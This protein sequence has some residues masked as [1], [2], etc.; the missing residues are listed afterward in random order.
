MSKLYLNGRLCNGSGK[1]KDEYTLAELKQ[2]AKD[3]GIR[4]TTK[5]DLCEKIITHKLPIVVVDKKMPIV[6]SPVIV[7]DKKESND[8]K[9]SKDKKKSN[10]KKKS[11]TL[12]VAASVNLR[13][14]AFYDIDEDKPYPMEYLEDYDPKL[15][16]EWYT[17]ILTKNDYY[18]SFIKDIK[19][20]AS[21]VH[22]IFIITYSLTGVG[23]IF[24]SEIA[25]PDNNKPLTVNGKDYT[26]FG[27]VYT[28]PIVAKANAIAKP[29]AKANAKPKANNAKPEHIQ[30]IVTSY[31][32]FIGANLKMPYLVSILT[33]GSIN[34]QLLTIKLSDGMIIDILEKSKINVTIDG[35]E[36]I[37]STK[38]I[39]NQKITNGF[40]FTVKYTLGSK[41][42]SP[43]KP[44]AVKGECVKSGDKKYTSRPS[45]PYPANECRDQVIVG[46][47]GNMYISKASTSGIYKWVKQK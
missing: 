28:K 26:V 3:N 43:P 8:K 35:K 22:G 18:K 38:V 5:T 27:S 19:V 40:I 1:T 42:K 20:E 37:I 24:P 12:T 25:D 33:D 11:K 9:E 41:S 30:Q 46:N 39:A 6:V 32:Q 44:A 45:P 2:I 10:D 4:G 36:Y 21:P 16:V 14:E 34:V 23:E 15:V 17:K 7:K 13:Y 29:T 31:K 47:D